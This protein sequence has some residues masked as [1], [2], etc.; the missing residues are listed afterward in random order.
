MEL[1]N[2]FVMDLSIKEKHLI[3]EFMNPKT[4]IAILCF[5]L[6]FT[7]TQLILTLIIK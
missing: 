7:L 2:N 3:F 1:K 5:L 4:I 6:G